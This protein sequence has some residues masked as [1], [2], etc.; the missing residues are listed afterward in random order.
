MHRQWPDSV[1]PAPFCR[2]EMMV[3]ELSRLALGLLVPLECS[4][5]NER[6]AAMATQALKPDFGQIKCPDCDTV[7]K[8]VNLP[9]KGNGASRVLEC[10]KCG[11]RVSGAAA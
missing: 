3:R 1:G 7:M 2:L 8:P 4:S 9:G 6:E 11:R 5:N 10:P